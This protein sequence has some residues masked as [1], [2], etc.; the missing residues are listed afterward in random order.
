[1][2]SLGPDLE[3]CRLGYRASVT[4]K[5]LL[6][7]DRRNRRL[8]RVGRSLAVEDREHQVEWSDGSLDRV[9]LGGSGDTQRLL[10]TQGGLRHG[11][12][13]DPDAIEREASQAPDAIFLRVLRDAARPQTSRQ[14]IQTLQAE[15]PACD[16]SGLWKQARKP[17]EERQDIEMLGDGAKRTYWVVRDVHPEATVMPPTSSSPERAG[18]SLV[19]PEPP[20]QVSHPAQIDGPL[21]SPEAIDAPADPPVHVNGSRDEPSK[22]PAPPET[23]PDELTFL[24]KLIQDKHQYTSAQVD[25]ISSQFAPVVRLVA[26]LVSREGGTP[27]P[28]TQSRAANRPLSSSA[29]L[30]GLPESVLKE[31]LHK[32]PS[33]TGLVAAVPRTSAVADSTDVIGS[34]G[35]ATAIALVQRGRAE[36]RGGTQPTLNG[37]LKNLITRT[38]A[39]PSS[40]SLS[41]EQLVAV[42]GTPR[43]DSDAEDLAA[44]VIDSLVRMSRAQGSKLWEKTDSTPLRDAARWAVR[45]PLRPGSPRVTLMREL[46]RHEIVDDRIWWNDADFD[47]LASVATTLGVTYAR[48]W[49]AREVLRPAA[50]QALT[51]ATTRARTANILAAPTNL[52]EHLDVASV[53][54]AIRRT[55]STDRIGRPLLER[56]SGSTRLRSLEEEI[57]CL[58]SELRTSDEQMK[59]TERR[60]EATQTRLVHLAEE[61]AAARQASNQARSAQLKQAQVDALRALA[62]VASYV[63]NGITRRTPDQLE[64]GIDRLVSRTGLVRVGELG[65]QT[66]YNP[67]LHDIMAAGAKPGDPVTVSGVGYVLKSDADDEIV[68]VRATVEPS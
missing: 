49:V 64:A 41:L 33:L 46:T 67:E 40:E 19:A 9:R 15:L 23:V 13:T 12:W 39:A 51:S 36:S 60:L 35:V 61:L 14:M 50:Q 25:A 54:S 27:D 28:D 8:L 21:R 24:R 22:D 43:P 11:I 37:S 7:I 53:E 48:E 10:V 16:A 47:D 29:V 2:D 17:L 1:M 26:A 6:E 57:E 65:E 30:A 38:L 56:L 52:A 45:L 42:A 63:H 58:R 55:W 62:Q 66:R 32:A 3:R 34:L 5:V 68:L 20:A 59:E 4:D 18:E 31:L 44:T